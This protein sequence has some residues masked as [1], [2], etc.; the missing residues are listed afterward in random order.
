[1]RNVKFPLTYI[2]M[3]KAEFTARCKIDRIYWTSGRVLKVRE[4]MSV[5]GDPAI[6]H[7]SLLK[8]DPSHVP[9]DSVRERDLY[10]SWRNFGLFPTIFQNNMAKDEIIG[11]AKG[12]AGTRPLG[13]LIISFSCSFR[14]KIR[15][16]HPLV[17]VGVP[18]PRKNP[19]SATATNEFKSTV[20]QKTG[21]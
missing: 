6:T 2:I 5:P 18:R 10:V 15:L 1:M 19:G 4:V 17:G 14:Q 20:C 8:R 11:W 16:A 21:K 13:V 12:G 9:A 7:P 3:H